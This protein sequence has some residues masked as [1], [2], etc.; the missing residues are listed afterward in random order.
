MKSFWKFLSF[1]LFG[2]IVA[3]FVK[4]NVGKPDEQI[5]I[6]LEIK[7]NKLFNK[8]DKSKRKIFN[9]KK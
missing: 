2:W 7:K 6:D 8:R 5:N 1:F 3:Y 4:D 9:R